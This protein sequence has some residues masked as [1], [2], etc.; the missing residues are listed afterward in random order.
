MQHPIYYKIKRSILSISTHG[1][2]GLV[3]LTCIVPLLW[4]IASSLKTQQT[5]FSDM[6]LFPRSPQWGNFY[7]AWTKGGFGQYFFN[8]LLY[9]VVVVAGIVFIASLAGYGISRLKIPG[10]NII[11]FI[12]ILRYR[13]SS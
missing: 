2:L 7:I 4:M 10:K 9:T 1:F 3:S 8:S 12:F 11:F 5:V 13:M 6:S